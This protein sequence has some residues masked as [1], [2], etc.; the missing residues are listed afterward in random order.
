[1]KNSE[2]TGDDAIELGKKSKVEK[3]FKKR[4]ILWMLT[5]VL[6]SFFGKST[7]TGELN[8]LLSGTLNKKVVNTQRIIEFL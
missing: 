4:Y 8:F 3:Y 2:L 1:M 6:F 7:K 5:N